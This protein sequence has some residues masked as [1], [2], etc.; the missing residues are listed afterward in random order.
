MAE[1]MYIARTAWPTTLVCSR[2]GLCDWL[3]S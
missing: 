2:T 1:Y 3:Y